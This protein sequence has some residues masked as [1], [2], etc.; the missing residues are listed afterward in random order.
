MRKCLLTKTFIARKQKSSSSRK[1]AATDPEHQLSGPTKKNKVVPFLTV[2]REQKIRE[3][4]R[5]LTALIAKEPRPFT[6]YISEYESRIEFGKDILAISAHGY[7]TSM[8]L[9]KEEVA[10]TFRYAESLSLGMLEH[11]CGDLPD[12]LFRGMLV[13]ILKRRIDD[14]EP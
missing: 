5:S 4:I 14:H 8:D 1:R 2:K 12:D 10:A 3:Q 7:P 11:I 13:E 6:D 9:L